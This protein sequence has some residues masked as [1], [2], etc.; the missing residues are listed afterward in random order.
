MAGVSPGTWSWTNPITAD[1]LYYVYI[2]ADD[3]VRKD[4]AVFRLQIGGADA[5]SDTG[6]PHI[7]TVNG[8]NYEL[9]AAGEFTL[10]RDREGMEI[11]IRQTPVETPP[12]YTSPY[13]GLT[14]CVSLN[15]ALAARVGSHR[16]AYLPVERGRY[17]FFLDGK[18]ALLTPEGIDLEGDRVSSFDVGGET[19]L[20]VDYAH[21]A[22]LTVTPRL[23]TSY[24]L[25]Y[26]D[27]SVSN[28]NGDEGLMGRIPK[29][30]WLPLL[31]SGA[32]VG[33]MPGSLHERHVALNRTFADAWRVTD[34]TSLF[35]YMPG[36]STAT[37][38]DRDW[39][40]E[41]PPCVLKPGF[42]KPVTPIR[43][44]IPIEKAKQICKGVTIKDLHDNCVFD[45]VTTGDAS[46]AK[47]YLVA[48]E[49]RLCGTAVQIV[50]DKPT[51]RPGQP[52]TVTAIVLPLKSGRPTPTGSVTFIIDGV[53]VKLARKLDKRGRAGFKTTSLKQ[54]EHKI[55]A[56][57]SGEKDGCHS[58]SSPNLLHTVGRPNHGGGPPPHSTQMPM[59]MPMPMKAAA[60]KTAPK[61]AAKKTTKTKA[62]S[63]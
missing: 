28:T 43:K 15:T 49:L 48:Q 20:R 14:E 63:K 16:I 54:G 7:R 40:S 25:W 12:P 62:K 50:G 10:L 56:T 13:S 52:L 37:F 4:Q 47:G 6:D 32:S 5:G 22:V 38:T 61:K 51:T 11:Q 31:P 23:W 1:G 8:T 46:F 53:P 39:P 58:S 2:T 29:G 30:T 19:G 24:G 55:R 21:N 18:P 9:Q 3:G 41:K 59:P 33:P 34:K 57:Y 42:Q 26:L 17:R 35:V 44:N 36:T 45:V 27:V 60:K